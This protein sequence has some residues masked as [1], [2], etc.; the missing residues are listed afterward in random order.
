MIP[1]VSA[2]YRDLATMNEPQAA[3]GNYQQSHNQNHPDPFAMK[4]QRHD[5]LMERLR[6]S[7]K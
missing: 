7:K 1:N 6:N 3:R 5:E 2:I 4:Q